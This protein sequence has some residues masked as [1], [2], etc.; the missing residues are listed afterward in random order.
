MLIIAW[1]L[2]NMRIFIKNVHACGM[3]HQPLIQKHVLAYTRHMLISDNLVFVFIV[4]WIL[5]T[6][7]NIDETN[8]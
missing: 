8:K 7:C 6:K 4:G 3:M 1:N 5:A 2:S